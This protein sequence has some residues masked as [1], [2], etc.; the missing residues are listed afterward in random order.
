M[1]LFSKKFLFSKYRLSLANIAFLAF[2]TLSAAA[3]ESRAATIRVAAG[4]VAIGAN[5]LCSLREA[6][7]NANNNA[8]TH[9]DCAAGSGDDTI[10]LPAGIYTTDQGAAG[11]DFSVTGDLDFRSNIIIN[12]E[13]RS[14]TVIQ[15]AATSGTAADRVL[16]VVSGTVIL[17]DLSVENGKAPDG[18]AGSNCASSSC[19]F[20]SRGGVGEAGGG[21]LNAGTLTLNRVTVS[22]NRSGGGGR[23]GLLSCTTGTC[24]NSGGTGGAGGGVSSSGTLTISDSFFNANQTGAGGPR[25]APTCTG[26]STFCSSSNGTRGNG[27]G[28]LGTATVI[29]RSVYTGNSGYDG[30]AVQ[31]NGLLT[32]NNTIFTGNSSDNTGGALNCNNGSL[33]CTIT[34]SLFTDNS[35]V[36]NGGAIAFFNGGTKTVTNTTISNNRANQNGGG[37]R[38]QSGA[39]NLSFVTIAG[40]TADNDNNTTGDGGGISWTDLAVLTVRNSVIADNIDRGGQAPDISGT[41]PSLGY[42]HIENT[43]GGVFTPTTGD[44]T[45]S[46]P[47]LTAL[48]DNGGLSQTHLPA[49]ASPLVDAIPVGV[50]GC[51]TGAITID[52]RNAFRA[53]DGNGDNLAACDKGA[54]ELG[55]LVG[56]IQAASEPADYIFPGNSG[57][58]VVRVNGDGTNFDFLRVTE[59]GFSHRSA[60][61]NIQTGKYWS[62]TPLAGDGTTAAAA[63]YSVD[64]TLPYNADQYDRVCRYEGTANWNCAVSDFVVGSSVT[65]RGI[66]QL[67]D[68]AVENNFA[69]TAARLSI[70]GRVFGAEGN[71][72]ANTAVELIDQ[73]GALRTTRT[74][75]FGFYCFSEIEAGQTVIVNVSAKGHVF[76]PHVVSL[77]GEIGE[78]NF[79][80]SA[81][82]VKNARR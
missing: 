70:A 63:D 48:A 30:G 68:W 44:V 54:V 21:I 12:G 17:N 34:G 23:A 79:Y 76:A 15:A 46:D 7:V 31:Q 5:G 38:A 40:N 13:G 59:I 51:G 49:A 35:T 37:I 25:T 27:G 60:P 1:K 19:A 2:L 56:G 50:N 77:T 72:L 75:S 71:A 53:T 18:A 58:A 47:Q 28:S 55:A 6:I 9:I 64:L 32:I 11:E 29:S 14:A 4:E 36:T 33:A 22:N 67:S 45:G 78:L 41:I 3:A 73:N 8:A 82:N 20:G 81:V 69:P 62:I 16:H 42:N 43:L 61:T 57:Q 26:S 39:I 52:Q 65:R 66:T 74:N 80:S 24:S 10:V